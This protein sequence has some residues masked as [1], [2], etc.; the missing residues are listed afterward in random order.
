MTMNIWRFAAAAAVTLGGLAAQPFQQASQMGQPASLGQPGTDWVRLPDRG[1][2][3]GQPVVGKPFSA[4]E[5]RKTMQTLA[6]G[7]LI[8]N[9]NTSLLYR[10]SQGR[11]RTEQTANGR[12]RIVIADPVA[13]TT[14]V[15]DPAAK[16]ARKTPANGL[17]PAQPAGAGVMRGGRSGG[18]ANASAS[19][20]EGYI[21]GQAAALRDLNRN[22]EDL[23]V[24]TVNGVAAE[25]TRLTQIV[26]AGKIG[27]NRDIHITNERWYSRDLDTLVKTV[28]SDPRFGV[29]TYQL[30]NIVQGTLDPALFQIPPDYT[31]TELGR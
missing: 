20:A 18:G 28:N 21:A 30:T 3:A 26:Q 6:D 24:Q 13:H 22:T 16:T 2:A 17:V 4:T 15:L 29:T 7:T 25:G 19:Y 23:G 9:T 10:D 11:I 12:T 31:V 14:I 8:E 27:N 5:E 1:G